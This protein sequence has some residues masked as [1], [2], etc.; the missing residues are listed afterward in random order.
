MNVISNI[1]ENITKENLVYSTIAFAGFLFFVKR[2][3]KKKVDKKFYN[4]DKKKI[5]RKFNLIFGDLNRTVSVEETDT[6]K[7]NCAKKLK[8]YCDKMVKEVKS[9]IEKEKGLVCKKDKIF[10]YIFNNVSNT[11]V[12][13]NSKV[14]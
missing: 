7:S 10:F 8:T 4:K 2:A 6:E 13:K 9:E 3:A 11:L 5:I 12:Q 1:Y 14:Y